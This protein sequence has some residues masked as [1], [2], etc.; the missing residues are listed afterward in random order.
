MLEGVV[1]VGDGRLVFGAVDQRADG[2]FVG[3]LEDPDHLWAVFAGEVVDVLVL[4]D[5]SSTS[6]TQQWSG[7]CAVCRVVVVGV[8]AA[9]ADKDELGSHG[10]VAFWWFG[11]GT[12]I[13]AGE[14]AL[15]GD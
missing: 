9:G 2:R 7:H 11:L 15:S 8:W 12:G 10:V 6:C 13:G 5:G 4:A 1:A 3:E 14:V